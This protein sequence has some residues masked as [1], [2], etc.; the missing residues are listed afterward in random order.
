MSN[1]NIEQMKKIIEDKKKKKS[2]QGAVDGTTG[3]SNVAINKG[4][5]ETRRGGAL[6]KQKYP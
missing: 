5:K 3:K 1:N 4:F 2:Q 6:N